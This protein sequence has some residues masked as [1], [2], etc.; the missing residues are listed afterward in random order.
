MISTAERSYRRRYRHA[1]L[2][3]AL[4]FA[5][6]SGDDALSK[7]MSV[8]SAAVTDAPPAVDQNTRADA[9]VDIGEDSATASEDA[10]SNTGCPAPSSLPAQY[11]CADV[12]DIGVQLLKIPDTSAGN[13]FYAKTDGPIPGWDQLVIAVNLES[14]G[15]YA[16]GA[17]TA[18]ITFTTKVATGS[19][20]EWVANDPAHG[21]RIEVTRAAVNA[22]DAYEGTF[23][24]DLPIRMSGSFHGRHN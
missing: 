21:C 10:T 7:D 6:C 2:L 8:D 20:V 12:G 9:A 13:G 19:E 23:S 16:C 11:A 24:T 3:V 1:W 14:V 18:S 17:N 4:A 5:A 22:G 15:S